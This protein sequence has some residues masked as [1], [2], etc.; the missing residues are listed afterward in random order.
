MKL[1]KKMVNY[2]GDFVLLGL[3]AGDRGGAVG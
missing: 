2:R 3:I 1:E